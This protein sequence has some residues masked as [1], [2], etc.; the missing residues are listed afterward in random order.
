MNK[1]IEAILNENNLC[2]LCTEYGGNPYCSLMTFTLGKDNKILY[3]VAIDDSKKYRNIALNPSVSILMDN[4]QRLGKAS[5]N[6]IIS[7]TFEGS[8]EAVDKEKAEEGKALLLKKHP[9]LHEIIQDPKCRLL[10][11][12]LKAYKLLMGPTKSEE[13]RI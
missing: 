9:D 13:G 5:K 8:Y 10:S 2:V 12:R 4:R 1:N 11:I 6:E 3:M 7:V